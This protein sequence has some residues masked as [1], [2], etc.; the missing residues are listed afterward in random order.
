MFAVKGDTSPHAVAHSA[1]PGNFGITHLTPGPHLLLTTLSTGGNVRIKIISHRE[2]EN[3]THAK[4]R[5][6]R[7]TQQQ[8]PLYFTENKKAQCYGQFSELKD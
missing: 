4:T 2:K 1:P 8:L 5:N 6:S 3:I 7:T